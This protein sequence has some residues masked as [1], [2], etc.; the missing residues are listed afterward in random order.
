M[1]K[2]QF[3]ICSSTTQTSVIETINKLIPFFFSNISF[4]LFFPCSSSTFSFLSKSRSFSKIFF[5]IFLFLSF[6]TNIFFSASL[7]F[8]L[9]VFSIS[10][11]SAE[12]ILF[13][14]F[15]F[16]FFYFFWMCLFIYFGSFIYQF[17]MGVFIFSVLFS[18]LFSISCNIFSLVF[19][20]PFFVIIIPYFSRSIGTCFTNRCKSILSKFSF[21]KI[22]KWFFNKT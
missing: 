16:I 19:F 6:V 22:T 2:R 1:I 14:V 8:L 15:I 20:Y 10:F 3:Y 17:S 7:P 4:S 13:P 18:N 5:L 12:I 9:Y 21:I 11:T